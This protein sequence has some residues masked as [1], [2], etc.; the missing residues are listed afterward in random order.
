[1]I[2]A[3]PKDLDAPYWAALEQ[4]RLNLPTCKNCGVWH[5]PP[6]SRCAECDSWGLDWHDIPL[7]GEIFSWT[8][9]WH[10]FGGTEGLEKPFVTVVV[11]IPAAGNRRLMGLLEGVADTAP[12][13]IG[14]AVKGRVSHT[15]YGETEIPTILWHLAARDGDAQ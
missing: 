5:W 6:V 13:P 14:A 15:R 4:G 12:V 11:A 8:R 3:S 2:E 10:P 7:E 1:M 9:T